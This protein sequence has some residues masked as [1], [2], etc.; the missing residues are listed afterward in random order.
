MN[1]MS[2]KE[3]ADKLSSLAQLDIDAVHAYDQA[4]DQ[5][6]HTGIRQQISQFR[7]DHNHH[8]QNLSKLITE[9]GETPPEFS[10]DFKGFFIEGFTAL[11]SATG[12]EGALKAMQTNE[13]MTNKKY[14]EAR[15]LPFRQ[16]IKAV[17]EQNYNDEARHLRYI[18]Q[19]LGNR[20][21]EK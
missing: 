1:H 4:I 10:R 9:L 13:N 5:I 11:R 15:S 17:V 14:D 18:E 3:M 12:T 6:E 21:W 19:A 7:E 8:V 20:S 2:N 16:D